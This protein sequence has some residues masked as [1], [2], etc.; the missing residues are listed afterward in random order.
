M[1]SHDTV[2][3]TG[4]R[5][6]GF[7]LFAL[8]GLSWALGGC[9]SSD[10]P[11]AGPSVDLDPVQGAAIGTQLQNTSATL[12][13]S[14]PDSALAAQAAQAVLGSGTQVDKV[15]DLSAA[16]V[17]RSPR[18]SAALTTGGALAVAFE[19]DLLNYP[20]TPSSRSLSG[21]LV[22]Q[23]NTALILAAGPA[24][25]SPIPPALGLLVSGGSVWSATAGEESA[26]RGS[27][28]GTCPK[29]SSLPAYVS[30]CSIAKFSNA[31]FNISASQPASAGASGSK[32][33]SL[34]KRSMIGVALTVDCSKTSICGKTSVTVPGAPTAVMAVA[35][36]GFAS[37]SW[38]PPA[39]N[40]GSPITGYTVTPSSGGASVTVG[41]V[42]Q[43]NVP[44]LTNGTSYTFT[45][46]ATNSKGNG[47]ESTPS[48]AVTPTP[49]PT[50]PGAPA[51]V[52]ATAGDAQATVTWSPPSSN[53][54]S[55]ITGYTVIS[56]P[57]G[58]HATAV[59][60]ATTATVMGLANGVAYTFT[61][62]AT[63]AIGNGPES[64]PSNAV[65]P[66]AGL[67]APGAPTGVQATA[68]N[69][70]AS[71]TWTP[72]SNTG[73]SPITDYTVTAHPGGAQTHS[74]AVTHASVGGLSNGT[75]YTFTVR[76]TNSVG[77]GPESQ[78]SNAV[79]PTCLQALPTIT[80]GDPNRS[81]MT[82]GRVPVVVD[83]SGRPIVAWIEY[84]PYFTFVARYDGG[85]QWTLLGSGFDAKSTNSIIY[86]DLA[87]EKSGNPV[88]AYNVFNASSGRYEILVSRWNGSAWDAVGP[89][90]PQGS[91]GSVGF[92]LALDASDHP[93]VAFSN[94]PGTR[95]FFEIAVAAWN[96][97]SWTVTNGI[98]NVANEQVFNPAIAI[99]A[100]GDVTVAW[101]ELTPPVGGFATF[102]PYAKKLT[103]PGAGL[104]PSPNTGNDYF[105]GGPAIGF[106]AGK[107]VMAWSDYPDLT[108][109]VSSLGLAV[110]RYSGTSW[111]SVGPAAG[112]PGAVP[113]KNG[114]PY[115]PHRLLSGHLG[116]LAAA[117]LSG[118]FFEAGIYTFNGTSW[119]LLCSEVPD[120]AQPDGK[121]HAI[122]ATGLAY[123]PSDAAHPADEAYVI[124]ASSTGFGAN[125]KL[126][127]A[128][129]KP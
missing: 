27:T 125:R 81:L 20:G 15:D 23:G 37:V 105:T 127:V 24:P 97:T 121:A 116:Q 69:G 109:G 47:P 91:S 31:G 46:H 110:T 119:N 55:A 12:A 50:V 41:P 101:D 44:N 72:P 10:K 128:R 107:L 56:S 28:V 95:P 66:S 53:G 115:N 62:H 58:F 21:V 2:R 11:A 106:D 104:V 92:A 98:Y 16:L 129:A 84:A 88:V 9:G 26:Q 36:D 118:D 61:V 35:H 71:V 68:G 89:A 29:A 85:T 70:M 43:A 79:T 8:I 93:V 18:R 30:G 7:A 108:A 73:G 103:G 5:G 39:N 17:A 102:H 75:S 111:S 124:T 96:G 74:G 14:S 99:D 90:V 65:T 82:P 77:D 51:A 42:T 25:S 38:T 126:F 59:G 32:H 22:F 120:P 4:G 1:R 76:A 52:H 40:G 67:T 117:T 57:G 13:A 6:S 60:T 48:S 63:N 113:E 114:T 49:G 122:D 123:F 34:S 45:V 94:Y 100:A 80:P 78:P 87:I 3:P 86:V 54:G 112:L 64:Q 19:I 33:A 83:P